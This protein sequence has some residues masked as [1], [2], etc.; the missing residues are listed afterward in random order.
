MSA[1]SS[2]N[3]GQL[4]V[5]MTVNFPVCRQGVN[6]LMHAEIITTNYTFIARFLPAR[7]HAVLSDPETT[8]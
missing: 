1:L 6:F 2:F 3:R 5:T 8:R 7:R 4:P